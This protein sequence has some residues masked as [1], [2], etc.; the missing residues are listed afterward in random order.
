MVLRLLGSW[1]FR[2]GVGSVVAWLTLA[3]G[4]LPKFWQH[5]NR[6]KA[7]VRLLVTR[8]KQG[9]PGDPIN[10][11]VQG[12]RGQLLCLF[13]RIG[14]RVPQRV[15]LK[16]AVKISAS[17]VVDHPYE[18]APVSALYYEGRIQDIAFEQEVGR[19]ANRRHHVRFW[20]VGPADWLGAATF[21]IG[22]GLNK[23]TG[24]ITHHI[25]GAVDK[26]RDAL[27]NLLVAQGATTGADR[28]SGLP[29]Q[30]V[31]RN[32]GGDKFTTDGKIKSLTVTHA[33][34]D[35]TAATGR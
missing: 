25:N 35:P 5:S 29:A 30:T 10:I 16:S 19:S 14:W 3:Y 23:Y 17:V 31:L 9:L 22:S 20:Q 8:T 33:C 12:D 21:D 32:G 18:T 11:A 15:S 2:I 1:F 4:L 7:E 24:Q 34:P 28:L 26:E 6:A 13:K 27:V